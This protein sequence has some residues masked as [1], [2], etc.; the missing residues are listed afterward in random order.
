M[1]TILFVEDSEQYQSMV[2]KILSHHKLIITD[3]PDAVESIVKEQK[4]DLILLDINLPKRDGYSVLSDLQSSPESASVPVICLTGKSAVSDKVT[5]FS[6]GAD[7]FIQ[8][9]FDP[10]EL[11]VRVDS[12]LLKAKKQRKQNENFQ[13]GSLRIDLNSHLV[14]H[15]SSKKEISLT[16]TEYK[17]LGHFA[18]NPGQVFTREQLLSIVWGNEGSVF[19]RAVDVHICSLR[20]KLTPYGVGFKSVPGIGYKLD[21]KDLKKLESNSISL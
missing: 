7:D 1:H 11:K 8:K 15:E 9:P 6:L 18:R 21:L 13:C 2:K 3:D 5:A 20:K 10:I 4:I 12:K 17:L 14:I 16:Q 19:D